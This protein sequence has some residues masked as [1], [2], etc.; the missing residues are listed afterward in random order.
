MNQLSQSMNQFDAWLQAHPLLAGILL[1]WVLAWKG[2]ALWRAAERKHLY[3][4]IA[5]LVINVGG[6]LEILYYFIF[7]KKK[8]GKK[9]ELP[10]E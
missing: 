1:V 3:W 7:S 8:F 6:V 4:F 9:K 10:T 2:L 5:M